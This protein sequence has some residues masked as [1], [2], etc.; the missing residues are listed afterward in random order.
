MAA[1]GLMSA[2][3]FK[4]LSAEE[5]RSRIE[6][7][8]ANSKKGLAVAN[9]SR[10]DIG[11]ALKALRGCTAPG[12]SQ[13]TYV[14]DDMPFDVES[15]ASDDGYRTID[16]VDIAEDAQKEQK[17]LSS[18]YQDLN[19]M[20]KELCAMLE[21]DPVRAAHCRAYFIKGLR[22]GKEQRAKKMPRPKGELVSCMIPTSTNSHKHKKQKQW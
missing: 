12:L 3:E 16:F 21:N 1:V 20:W 11:K 22:E 4:L 13:E 19:P 9:Y 10:P 7:T 2:P 15:G 5:L 18:V 8:D 17:T 14:P 6:E